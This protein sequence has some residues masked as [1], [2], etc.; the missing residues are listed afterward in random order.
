MKKTLFVLS[1]AAAALTMSMSALADP[2]IAEIGSTSAGFINGTNLLKGES[3][4]LYYIANMDGTAITDAVYTSSLYF[5][6][7]LITA[8]QASSDNLNTGGAF[9]MDGTIVIPM[10]YGDVDVLSDKWA[11][12]LKLKLADANQYDY[13]SWSSDNY[14]LIETADIFYIQGTSATLIGSLP[15]ANYKDSRA[16]G[17]YIIIEDRSGGTVRVYDTSFS[18]VEEGLNS[19]YADP[20]NVS[21]GYTTFSENGQQGLKDENGN[22]IVQPS[23][24]YIYNVEEGY[25]NVST[26]DKEGLIDLQGNVI[27]PAQYDDIVSNYAGPST[28]D[29]GS[30]S[31]SYVAANYVAVE[32][33]GKVGY[34]DLNGNV[35]MEPRYSKDI[36]DVN[37]ASALL[38]DLEGNVHI[39]AADGTDTVLDSDHKDVR[40]LDYSNGFLYKVTTPDYDYGLIDWHGNE[41]LPNSYNNIDL[42]GDGNYLLARSDYNSP[43]TLYQVTY[44]FASSAPAAPA[45]PA[46]DPGTAPAPETTASS[47]PSGAAGLLDSAIS[48]NSADFDGNKDAIYSLITTSKSMIGDTNPNC[49]TLLTSALSLIDSGAANADSIGALLQNAR[50]M[51]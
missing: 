29:L 11:V 18:V 24:K 40:V 43:Y 46:A 31:F 45:A 26:G 1:V 8:T 35:T 48:L 25:V 30:Y 47:D 17:N 21:D 2:S 28:D 6:K 16:Y 42:S 5:E 3:N 27:V 10:E 7:G 13:E 9:S 33:D 39:L 20:K 44:D 49:T 51:L 38:T 36:L 15:R 32:Q 50:G 12:G 22:V 34:V 37:G 23:Y 4:G 41:L 19:V 14:F